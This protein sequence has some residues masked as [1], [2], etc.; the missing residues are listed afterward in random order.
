M[1]KKIKLFNE[2]ES[3]NPFLGLDWRQPPGQCCPAKY[4]AEASILE[5]NKDGHSCKLFHLPRV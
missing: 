3:V 4:Y 5:I 1:R 2:Q